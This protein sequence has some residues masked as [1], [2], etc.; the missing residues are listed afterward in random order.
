MVISTYGLSLKGMSVVRYIGAYNIRLSYGEKMIFSFDKL[1]IF[2]GDKIGLIGMNGS[3]KTS[4]LNILNG[5]LE[6]NSG[7]VERD[8]SISYLRQFHNIDDQIEACEGK[9]AGEFGMTHNDSGTYSGG[10]SERNMLTVAWSHERHILFLDEPTSNLDA[11]GI[12]IVTN[13]LKSEE[14]FILISHDRRLLDEVCNKII[15][16]SDCT[17]NV[18]D[19]NF[20]DYKEL[21]E[22][23]IKRKEFEYIQYVEEKKRLENSL[24]QQKQKAQKMS[25]A[26]GKISSSDRKAREFSAVGRSYS[27]KEKAMN[28]KAKNTQSRIDHLEVKT[29]PRLPVI[30]RPCFTLTNPPTS[31]YIFRSSSMTFSYENKIIFQNALFSIRNKDKVALIGPNGS[32]KTTLLNLIYNHH[33]DIYISPQVKIGYQRQGLYDLDLQKSVYDN[34]KNTAVQKEEVIINVLSRLGFPANKL[35]QKAVDLSGGEK[36]KLNL[37]KL[38]VSDVNVLFLDEVTNYLD[39]ESIEALELFLDSFEGTI[40]F[41]SH[42]RQFIREIANDILVIDNKKIIRNNVEW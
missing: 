30:I 42:D 29:K 28:R 14:T 39:M 33:P 34:A 41:A 16:I 25:K 12:N 24:I 6:P 23:K 32:G 11:E 9:L 10:E 21:K 4:L 20:S 26:P 37:A 31:K 8:C 22:E 7:I 5:D 27:G 3:G 19:G 35:N 36:V 1:E 38:F 40:V 18:Y 15:E 13:K 17:I 2:A